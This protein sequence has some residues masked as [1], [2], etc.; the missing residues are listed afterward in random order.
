MSTDP[1]IETEWSDVGTDDAGTGF[2]VSALLG[3]LVSIVASFVPFSP[4][5]GGG[6]AGYLY[7]GTREEGVKV[8]AVSGAI[9]AVPIVAV[10]TLVF[11]GLGLFTVIENAFAGTL[12]FVALLGISVSVTL[13]LSAGLSAL[14]GYVG[15]YLREETDGGEP[16]RARDAPGEEADRERSS[17]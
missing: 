12:L 4:V 5:L 16:P 15:V 3:A 7:R 8:G 17:A 2:W 9:A 11:A 6:V 10:L 13:L 14:G 1:T